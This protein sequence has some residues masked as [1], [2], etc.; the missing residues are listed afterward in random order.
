MKCNYSFIIPHK[1]SPKLLE[2]CLNS[3]PEREDI[4]II[5]VD[6]NSDKDIVDFKSFPGKDKYNVELIFS[7]EGKGAG[8]A[9]NIGLNHAIGKWLLFADADD[10]YKD[11]FITILDKYRDSDIDVLYFSVFSLDSDTLEP[12]NRS[13]Q[14]DEYISEFNVLKPESAD[15]IR[16]NK[17]EIWNKMIK[18][19]LIKEHHIF[20]DEYGKCN[21]MTFSILTSY[22]S[23]KFNI[24][25]NCLYCITYNRRS[26]TYKPTTPQHFLEIRTAVRKKNIIMKR[27]GHKEWVMNGFHEHIHYLLRDGIF[28]YL[29]NLVFLIKNYGIMRKEIEVFV[30]RI[31]WP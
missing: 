13:S 29:K 22:Y 15:K 18:A 27:I 30:K 28:Q 12:S 6:D 3:I 20:F 21:D 23:H 4:Q 16:F 17:W 24:I 9:R 10:F 8:F 2:R 19:S 11:G 14:Y 7:K 25:K 31:E 26:L 5:V 1:N